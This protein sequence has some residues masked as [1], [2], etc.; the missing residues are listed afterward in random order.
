MAGPGRPGA[1][2]LAGA[3]GSWT[4]RS[5]T[6]HR[7]GRT[8]SLC[9]EGVAEARGHALMANQGQGRDCRCPASQ[10]G[11]RCF[12]TILVAVAV[13]HSWSRLTVPLQ[14]QSGLPLPPPPDMAPPHPLARSGSGSKGAMGVGSLR[15]RHLNWTHTG[16]LWQQDVLGLGYTAVLGPR[17]LAQACWGEQR[18]P[19][20]GAP[21]AQPASQAPGKGVHLLHT[22]SWS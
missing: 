4:A 6:D 22:L 20:A 13:R 16:K 12:H 2:V 21:P 15:E 3:R 5:S 8:S 17:G 1:R 18:W 7:G 11:P 9:S 10:P 14:A 19:E